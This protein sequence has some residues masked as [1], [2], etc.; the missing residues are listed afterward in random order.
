MKL[1]GYDSQMRKITGF[2]YETEKYIVRFS[3]N[4]DGDK[5]QIFQIKELLDY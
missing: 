2:E 1:T 4:A 3:R 5:W